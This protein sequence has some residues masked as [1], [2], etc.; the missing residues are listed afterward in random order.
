MILINH[1]IAIQ[2]LNTFLHIDNILAD[3]KIATTCLFR[4]NKLFCNICLVINQFLILERIWELKEMGKHDLR[5]FFVS[6]T[7][8]FSKRVTPEHEERKI[9]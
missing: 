2:V 8:K 1:F 3:F 9:N 5:N 4:S 6:R 7:P